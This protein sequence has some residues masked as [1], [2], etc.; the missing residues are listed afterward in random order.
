MFFGIF[1]SRS[2]LFQRIS[3]LL[4]FLVAAIWPYAWHYITEFFRA[5]LYDRTLH[6]LTEYIDYVLQYGVSVG[7]IAFGLWLFCITGRRSPIPARPIHHQPP[8][9]SAPPVPQ[10][11]SEAKSEINFATMSDY[12]R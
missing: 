7:L 8:D 3:G 12:D 6:M 4:A 5:I 11:G 1:Q 9:A 2:A 10:A